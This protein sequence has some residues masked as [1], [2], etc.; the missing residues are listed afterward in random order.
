MGLGSASS[1]SSL[2]YS[3]QDSSCSFNSAITIFS[4]AHDIS[5]LHLQNFTIK[6]V[7]AKTFSSVSNEMN[8]ILLTQIQ[9]KHVENK[10]LCQSIEKQQRKGTRI[11]EHS[12]LLQNF[13]SYTQMQSVSHNCRISF[14]DKL[15]LI[16]REL[17]RHVL[18]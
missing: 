17:N 15:T 10:H 16:T 12:W 2:H 9:V 5:C 8:A 11:K 4:K 3:K 13:F 18:Y 7:L 1:S 14:K 6:R